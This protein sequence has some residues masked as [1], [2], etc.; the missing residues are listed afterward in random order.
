MRGE[1]PVFIKLLL[2]EDNNID[3]MAFSRLVAEEN[4]PYDCT[5]AASIA[6]A[7]KILKST[8]FDIVL[9][10]YSLGDGTGFDIFDSITDTPI[11][12]ITG[13]GDEETAIKAMKEGVY[14]YVIKDLERN[15]LKKLPITVENAIRRR[16]A[17]TEHTI[18]SHALMSTSDSVFVTGSDDRII[19]V[20]KAF[21][22]TYGYRQEEVL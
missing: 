14:D 17:E 3:A 11:I 19:L 22:D 13:A 5:R 2:I 10:D 7:R 18:L 4:L 15:Y 1:T 8:E 21:C 9:S 16:K 20:N 12:F 6:E